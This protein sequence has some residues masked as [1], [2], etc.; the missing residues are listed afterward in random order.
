[1]LNC[2][3]QWGIVKIQLQVGHAILKIVDSVSLKLI[4]FN[5]RCIILIVQSDSFGNL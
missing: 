5:Y 3:V 1:M 2:H 4:E